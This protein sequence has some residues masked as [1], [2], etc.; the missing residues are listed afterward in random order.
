MVLPRAI[1]D[2]LLHV[3][4]EVVVRRADGGWLMS[5][6]DS[7]GTVRDGPDGLPV[8]SIGRPVTTAEVLEAIAQERA[9]R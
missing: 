6:A 8:L 3:P 4:G 1:R 9:D 5:A 2:E 7:V